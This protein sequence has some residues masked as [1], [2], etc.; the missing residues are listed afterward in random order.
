MRKG[1]INAN[2]LKSADTAFLVDDNTIVKTGTDAEI[3]RLLTI[4]EEIIDLQGMAVVPGFVDTHMHLLELG[5]YLY[6]ARLAGCTS[7]AEIVSR[8]KAFA[9]SSK[10][11]GWIKGR[12]YNED[13]FTTDEKPD[14]ALLDSVSTEYPV[15]I[16]RACGHLLVANSKALELAG[17][18]EETQVEGGRIDFE[19][20]IVEENAIPLIHNAEPAPDEAMLEAYIKEGASFCSRYGI[21]TVGSDDFLSVVHDW[22][23]VLNVFEKMSF[24]EELDVRINEQCEFSSPKEFASFLDEGYT[25]DV[26]NDFFRIGP[27]KLITDGSLG[28]RTA[29]LAKPYCDA[30]GQS[31]YMSM[32]EED[33]R[34]Y[35]ELASRF[36]MPV[37]CHAIG[38]DAVDTCIRVL[39]D[40]VYEGN[41]LHSGLV[42]LQILRPE[43]IRRIIDLKLSCYYQTL[44]ID[45]DATILKDRVGSLADSCYPYASL[46]RGTLCSNGSDAPVEVPDVLK[47]I[48]LA[49]TRKSTHEGFAMNPEE[50]L[51]VEE[52]LDSYTVNGARQFFMDD[53]IGAVKAGMYAD[54]AVLSQDILHCDPENIMNTKV[55]MTVMNGRTVFER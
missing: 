29:A 36:N 38:D 46:F 41:P 12:G 40:V 7:C 54:F 47:G 22:R 34:L 39:K 24:Q 10:M 16:T 35:A 19:K 42:H 26:G 28:A 14:K 15:V 17:I 53:R 9:N 1:Y 4:D 37:I 27:L 44:F 5:S 8:L 23:P 21:T 13:L 32:S 3:S 6:H 31:G 55:M 43:Q 2:I 52:A 50:C 30:P 49:V 51:T 45:Y 11:K 25:T 48:Q 33:I 20:G 18:T